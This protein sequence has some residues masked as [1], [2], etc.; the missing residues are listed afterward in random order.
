LIFYNPSGAQAVIDLITANNAPNLS[1]N[2]ATVASKSIS[3]SH[4]YVEFSPI[5]TT[6]A[7]QQ[8]SN[9][10]TGTDATT[11][12]YCWTTNNTIF[13]LSN[14]L[15]VSACG[16]SAVVGGVQTEKLNSL[17]GTLPFSATA[18]FTNA[19]P[20]ADVTVN[21]YLLTTEKKL[22]SAAADSMGSIVMLGAVYPLAESIFVNPTLGLITKL[23]FTWGA[24]A[25]RSGAGK[26]F[27]E[28]GP[29][30]V[31]FSAK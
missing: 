7:T 30:T 18:S 26:T 29:F 22:A 17:G 4:I 20:N 1:G 3:A 16:S 9:L 23:N 10:Q 31:K 15:P 21:A 11:G 19:G 13:I 5:S 2:T 12:N 27:I 8:F 24:E 6:Q 25:F 14:T 28:G